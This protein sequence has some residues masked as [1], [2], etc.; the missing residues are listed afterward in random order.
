MDNTYYDLLGVPISADEI[1]LHKAFRNLSKSFHPDTTQ[2]PK[3]EAIKRF[4]EVREAYELLADPSLREAY[5]ARL[6]AENSYRNSFLANDTSTKRGKFINYKQADVRRPLSGGELFSLML[7]VLA[8]LLSLLM[9]ILFATVKT[10]DLQPLPSW[11]PIDEV[12]TNFIA[13]ESKDVA[14][15]TL[16]HST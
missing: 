11:L 5:D 9:G 10:Q 13:Q 8:L 14:S 6:K 12:N 4:Q 2:L 7:L 1:T 16:E 3:E 15:S